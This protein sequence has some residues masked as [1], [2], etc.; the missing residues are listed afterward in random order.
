MSLEFS[1]EIHCVVDVRR[2]SDS[3]GLMS[4]CLNDRDDKDTQPLGGNAERKAGL[5]LNDFH[6]LY[7]SNLLWYT[8]F[9]QK[10]LPFHKSNQPM[11]SS[12]HDKVNHLPKPAACQPLSIHINFRIKEVKH[13]AHGHEVPNSCISD[14]SPCDS[15]K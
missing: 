6:Q 10:T 5:L 2:R 14:C 8:G 4:L 7:L 9:T 15:W 1:L 3:D 13:E 12:S 11:Q